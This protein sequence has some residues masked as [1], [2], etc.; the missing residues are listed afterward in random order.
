[1]TVQRGA[2]GA[3]FLAYDT[4]WQRPAKT[5][6]WAFNR[7][8]ALLPDWSEAVYLA[9]PWATLV[10]KLQTHQE[11]D[12]LLSA[13]A[14]LS[15]EARAFKRVVTVCQHILV[16][17]YGTLFANA[18]VTDLFWS[19]YRSDISAIASAEHI[20]LRPFPLF[21]VN[22]PGPKARNLQ[23]RHLFS[24]V[25]A[26]NNHWYLDN[27]RTYIIEELAGDP[28][29]FI[30]KRANWH[31]ADV[32]YGH[33]IMGT[34]PE[35]LDVLTS[36]E[37]IEFAQS[38]AESVFS[39]CPSGSGVNSLR[40]W[41]SIDCGAIPVVLSPLYSPPGNPALWAEGTIK[42]G[43]N[44]EDVQGIPDMLRAIS[45][46]E[47]R[48]TRMRN[49]GAQLQMLYGRDCFVY[50]IISLFLESA[51][52]PPPPTIGLAR[53]LFHRVFEPSG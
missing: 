35:P 6:E 10:D 14:D 27:A 15:D 7:A 9:F 49:A 30:R 5:E 37:A 50:D 28:R 19:H 40:L 24:Y 16:P 23:K 8:Y 39:L 20:N 13:L 21:P 31:Y 1:M 38:L 25:G 47:S 22:S 52:K 12:D 18:G 48:L 36:P 2:G 17:Q 41:E 4:R 42:V 26:I 32:V 46:D 51:R 44:R 3:N 29:G 45:S 53:R 11:A 33:Q 34:S 43:I